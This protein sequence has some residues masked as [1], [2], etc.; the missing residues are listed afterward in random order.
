MIYE[1]ES[2]QLKMMSWLCAL[3]FFILGGQQGLI[4]LGFDSL[5]QRSVLKGQESK[6]MTL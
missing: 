4:I 3:D 5:Q 1:E 2:I 6:P